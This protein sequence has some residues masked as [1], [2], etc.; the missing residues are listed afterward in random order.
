MI[1]SNRYARAHFLTATADEE[2][3]KVYI[4]LDTFRL[5]FNSK[6]E[7]LKKLCK[8]FYGHIEKYAYNE[9]HRRDVKDM[10]HAKEIFYDALVRWR[11][12]GDIEPGEPDMPHNTYFNRELNLYV[13]YIDYDQEWWIPSSDSK[14][15][16]FEWTPGFDPFSNA[17]RALNKLLSAANEALFNPEVLIEINNIFSKHCISENTSEACLNNLN[18]EVSDRAEY[19][20]DFETHP[21]RI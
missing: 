13:D 19:V 21:V 20:N 4:I 10:L 6:K 11:P 3:A 7:H 15:I 12:S 16:L 9:V 17:N 1:N 14:R 18:N 8:A 2:M 5:D